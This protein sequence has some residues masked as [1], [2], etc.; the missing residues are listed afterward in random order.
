MKQP[1]NDVFLICFV[2]RL[3]FILLF[4]MKFFLYLLTCNGRN[5][6]R[7][8][9]LVSVVLRMSVMPRTNRILVLLF[10]ISA[11]HYYDIGDIMSFK[12]TWRIT[13][14]YS[15][16]WIVSLYPSG[17]GVRRHRSDRNLWKDM[18]TE[19]TLAR[20]LQKLINILVRRLTWSSSEGGIYKQ[21]KKHKSPRAV[22]Q[23]GAVLLDFFFFSCETY[24]C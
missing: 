15:L 2:P 20:N 22:V 18:T 16:V 21:R 23:T 17:D 8:F 7:M 10:M 19:T 1:R 12:T 9:V 5:D 3:L 24:S 14:F 6:K 4:F 13:F 11:L